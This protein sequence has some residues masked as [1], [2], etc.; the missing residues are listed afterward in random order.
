MRPSSALVQ[1]DAPVARFAMRFFC[2]RC[3][4]AWWGEWTR[5]LPACP[6][7]GA[8]LRLSRIWDLMTEAY[9]RGGTMANP[10]PHRARFAKK[11]RGKPGDLEAVTRVLW[12]AIKA[13]ETVLDDAESHAQTLQCTHAL[14][15]ACTAYAR[16]LE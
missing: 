7:C 8:R 6:A 11:R 14:A 5:A 3:H 16:L 9:R 10:D 4:R 15:Q 2:G 13:A 1:N 12:S